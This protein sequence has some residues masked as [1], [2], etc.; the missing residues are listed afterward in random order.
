MVTCSARS[1]KSYP[2][3]GEPT[4]QG[5]GVPVIRPADA[6]SQLFSGLVEF[7]LRLRYARPPS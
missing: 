5:N 1:S 2:T 6:R 3:E 4:V 7:P